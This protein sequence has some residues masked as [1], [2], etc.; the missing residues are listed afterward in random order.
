[1]TTTRLTLEGAS[2]GALDATSRARAPGAV[3]AREPTEPGRRGEAR[4]ETKAAEEGAKAA[5]RRAAGRKRR[6]D[7]AFGT[8]LNRHAG[9]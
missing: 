4:R 1:M 9:S 7:W 3:G 2:G 8:A 6:P 5:R